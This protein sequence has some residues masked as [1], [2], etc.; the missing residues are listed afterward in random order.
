[1]H[2]AKYVKNI[3]EVMA[4]RLTQPEGY[5]RTVALLIDKDM[6]GAQNISMGLCTIDPQSQIPKHAHEHE[7]EAMYILKGEGIA[8]I[9]D[10]D[11]ILSEG[12]VVFCPPKVI[13]QIVNPNNQKLWFIFTYGPGGPEQNVKKIGKPTEPI[14]M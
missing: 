11:Y 5:N 2:K 8:K 6:D 3:G 9:E 7:E 12:S 4:Y 14:K 1:M 10:V 13:H